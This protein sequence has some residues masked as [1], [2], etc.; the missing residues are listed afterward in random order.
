MREMRMRFGYYLP[1]L[2]YHRVGEAQGDHVPTVSSAAFERQLRCLAAWRYRV[3]SLDE[4]V[5]AVEQG[6]RAPTRRV[7]ITFDDGYVEVYRIAWPL[8]RRFGFPATIFVTPSEVGLPGFATWDQVGEMARDGVAL[9]SHTL[10]HTYLPLASEEQL[11]EEIVES[12]RVIEARTGA[13]VR[14]ISY[15]VGGFTP[16]AIRV[17]REAGYAAGCTTNRA[18]SRWRVE[19]FALRRIKMTER[20]A[21]PLVLRTKVSGYYDLF[22]RLRP[23]A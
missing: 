10:H 1:I 4:V 17:A 12:K 19:R 6:G 11:V 15:P 13:V 9:G 18:T 22:R 21:T 5:E 2:G 8:L 23:P 7:A 14:Y 16:L 3:L 20:D